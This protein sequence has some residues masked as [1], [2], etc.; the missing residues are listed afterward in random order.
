MATLTAAERNALPSS[1]FAL[2]EAREYPIPDEDHARDA[3]ARVQ[4]DGTEDEK[5]R[6][7]AAVKEKYPQM[8]I[9]TAP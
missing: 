9:S 3:L 2:P 8:D 1:E 4:H 5:R 6:V 7:Y